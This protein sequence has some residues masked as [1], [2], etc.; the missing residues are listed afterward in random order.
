[1]RLESALLTSF[2]DCRPS[3]SLRNPHVDPSVH[4]PDLTR[5]RYTA[6]GLVRDLQVSL[7]LDLTCRIAAAIAANHPVSG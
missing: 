1:M 6:L 3:F 4:S 5:I 2:L 7:T